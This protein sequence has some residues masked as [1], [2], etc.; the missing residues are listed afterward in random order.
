MYTADAICK[1]LEFLIGNIVVR[2]GDFFSI[3]LLGFQWGR[4][5]LH[6][7]LTFTY[8]DEFFDNVITSGHR[9]LDGS[10]NVCHRYTDDLIVLR[11]RSFWIL[12]Y[13]NVIY[14]FQF[15]FEKAYKSDHLARYLKL[16]YVIN[17]GGKL[18][19]KL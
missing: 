1:M 19:I 13:L 2:L 18:S 17:S 14:L 4:T 16:T 8:E 9:R 5:V 7:L 3:R 10:F 6:Y 12:D 11:T 15:T